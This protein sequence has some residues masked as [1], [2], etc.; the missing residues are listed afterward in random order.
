MKRVIELVKL[1]LKDIRLRKNKIVWP[2]SDDVSEFILNVI[3]LL[4]LAA[5]IFLMFDCF[6]LAAKL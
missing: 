1:K 4:F 5:M 6:V 3:Y 2:F